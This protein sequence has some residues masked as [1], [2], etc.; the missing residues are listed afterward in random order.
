MQAILKFLRSRILQFAIAP[1]LVIGWYL[2]T[3]PSHGAETQLRLQLL[4][5]AFLLN[6]IAFVASKA[7]LGNACSGDLYDQ[8]ISGN[9]AAGC[10]FVGV[11]IVRAL[12]LL[13][14][15]LFFAMVQR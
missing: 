13:G 1:L 11:C 5:Q 9:L 8:A 2:L 14:L 10:A 12:T 15:L 6:G 4:A 3:D 7:L